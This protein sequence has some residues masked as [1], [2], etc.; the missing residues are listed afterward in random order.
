M[1]GTFNSYPMKRKFPKEMMLFHIRKSMHPAQYKKW[2]WWSETGFTD[3]RE[4]FHFY[5]KKRLKPP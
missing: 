3:A 1:T 4:K 5:N 2:R